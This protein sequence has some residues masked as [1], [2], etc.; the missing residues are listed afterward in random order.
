MAALWAVADPEIGSERYLESAKASPH[1]LHVSWEVLPWEVPPHQEGARSSGPRVFWEGAGA[2]V[3]AVAPPGRDLV[4]VEPDEANPT[5]FAALRN[6]QP[7]VPQSAFPVERV[8]PSAWAHLD[9]EA[10]RIIPIL[11]A[12]V[13]TASLR[14]GVRV[15]ELRVQSFIDPEEGWT[16]TII[17]ARVSCSP[18]Q[19]LAFW[20]YI[21]GQIDRWKA[22]LPGDQADL[23]AETFSVCVEW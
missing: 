12:V 5:T 22:T 21:G 15:E 18:V 2:S 19:A 6:G 14:A 13:V 20:D 16:R 10:R 7:A 1:G 9:R 23:V 17:V 4:V 11:R 3:D 8:D